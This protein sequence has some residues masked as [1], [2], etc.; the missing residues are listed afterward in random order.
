MSL[1]EASRSQIDTLIGQHDIT[2]FMKGNRQQPQCGF[3]STV[4]QILDRLIPD[5]QT[6]DVLSDPA[7]R[8]NIKLYSSWPTIPQL[9]VK[10][11]FIGGCDII[12]RARTRHGRARKRSWVSRWPD[13]R[14]PGS[15]TV[16]IERPRSRGS[17]VPGALEQQGDP[18]PRC[19]TSRST[20]GYQSQR[21][22]WGPVGGQVLIEVESRGVTLLVDRDERQRGRTVW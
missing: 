13:H 11:E 9:Y 19:F 4:V 18:E 1:D 8:E 17:C 5:Y 20:R 10:G 15:V 2:L 22:A 3:S 21:S 7:I 16:E 14:D 6:V 12:H